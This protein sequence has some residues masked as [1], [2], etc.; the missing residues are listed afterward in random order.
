M[1][2]RWRVVFC[3]SLASFELSQSTAEEMK[4]RERG[5][6]ERRGERASENKRAKRLVREENWKREIYTTNTGE[7]KR[8]E[9]EQIG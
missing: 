4:Q 1:L 8:D 9:S 3:S 2:Y 6:C 7:K 5:G